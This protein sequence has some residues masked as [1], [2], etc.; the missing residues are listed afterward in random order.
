M[1]EKIGN[2]E[3]LREGRTTHRRLLFDRGDVLSP[4][5]PGRTSRS[6][7][8]ASSHF[9]INLVGA[10]LV[11]SQRRVS[12]ASHPD[13]VC[14]VVIHR[15]VRGRRELAAVPWTARRQPC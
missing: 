8:A 4:A 10:P 14:D 9:A 5:W 13:V 1:L 12:H 6:R 7:L 11:P 15:L 2:S 3:A